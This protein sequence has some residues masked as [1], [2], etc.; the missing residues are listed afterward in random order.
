MVKYFALQL[1]LIGPVLTKGSEPGN[2]GI[3]AVTLRAPDGSLVINGKHIHGRCRH[4]AGE[5]AQLSGDE[6]ME[7]WVNL[8]FGPKPPEEGKRGNGDW[9]PLRAVLSFEELHCKD[10]SE[11]PRNAVDFRLKK[12]EDTEAG[13]DRMLAVFERAGEH[14][15]R[16]PFSG[17]VRVVYTSATDL[18]RNCNNLLHALRWLTNIGGAVGVGYGLIQSSRFLECDLPTTVCTEFAEGLIPDTV[19]LT[20]SF[21]EPFC[22]A[23]PQLDEN[24]F[25][26]LDIVP[27]S[28]IAGAFQRAM[29]D[30]SLGGSS[31]RFATLRKHFNK[32]R[33][34]HA[35]PSNENSSERPIPTPLS[36]VSV[37][38]SKGFG[39]N[40]EPANLID[41]ALVSGPAFFQV[42]SKDCI[43][44]FVPDWK[45]D[46]KE[47]AAN[48]TQWGSVT[49]EL[50]MY[51]EI[52]P[53]T[54]VA[55]EKKLY[56]YELARPEGMVW[57]G[58][59]DIPN[60]ISQRERSALIDEFRMLL[61]E[62]P[63]LLGKTDARAQVRLSGKLSDTV[64]V[65]QPNEIAANLWIVTLATQSMLLDAAEMTGASEAKLAQAYSAAWEEICLQII[66]GKKLLT[67]EHYFSCEELIGSDYL[68]RRFR[69]AVKPY[70][71]YLLT[72]AGSVF[73][74]KSDPEE[75]V[76]VRS[77]FAMLLRSGIPTPN[78]AVKTFRRDGQDGDYWNNCPFIP[79]NGFG[80]IVVNHAAQLSRLHEKMGVKLTPVNTV[81]CQ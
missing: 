14:G 3:D 36:W 57:R 75:I 40:A 77:L 81:V 73:V 44:N 52:E 19:D 31:E 4:S 18:D 49:R 11:R 41:A 47:A 45:L 42:D 28:A 43:P 74:L 72:G 13:E 46:E 55:K 7:S 48:A 6:N 67:L 21:A 34:R 5:L 30:V 15:E 17:Y 16:L 68:H 25:R 56:A 1:D 59:M 8:A 32:I 24:V 51:T 12:D 26:C 29:E 65:V 35:F 78:W 2:P 63:L 58:A 61:A 69:G 70:H 38:A 10:L 33:F 79:Q 23:A 76:Q 27:G 66:P 37:A 9:R 22:L 20:L 50:R 80:E 53:G 54:G 62:S 39:E 71:P 60:G 64:S